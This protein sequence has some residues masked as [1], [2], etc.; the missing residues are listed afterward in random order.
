MALATDWET[1]F[2]MK[3]Q[4][5]FPQTDHA[6]ELVFV[7][8]ESVMIDSSD[9]WFWTDEWQSGEKRVDQHIEKGEIEKFSSMEDFL[10]TLGD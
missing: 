10:S 5:Y 6:K 1:D 4:R 2:V 8:G 7:N 3:K 9:K